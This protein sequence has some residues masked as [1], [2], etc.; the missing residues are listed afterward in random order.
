MKIKVGVFLIIACAAMVASLATATL[1]AQ[2]KAADPGAKTTWD[3]VYSR[4]Q[5]AQGEQLYND[6]C[7]KCHGP[8][9]SGADAPTLSGGEFASDW[10][11]MT[12]GQLFD[13]VRISMPQDNPQSLSREETAA[14][15]AY[16]FSKNS[17]PA[18]E[19]ALSP[20]GEVLTQIKYMANKP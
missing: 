16:I 18:G 8:E 7:S 1:R 20:Q 12:V 17:F 14:L 10:D 11:S 2:D 3:G 4:E 9:A 19:A 6:K 13:R 15:L 5:A